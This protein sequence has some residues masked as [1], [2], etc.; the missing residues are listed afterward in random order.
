MESAFI[1]DYY[2]N[3]TLPHVYNVIAMLFS[4]LFKDTYY[5]TINEIPPPRQVTT[6]FNSTTI[7]CESPDAGYI[8]LHASALKDR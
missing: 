7:T 8:I 6:S 5:P 3:R 2:F 1:F 4:V